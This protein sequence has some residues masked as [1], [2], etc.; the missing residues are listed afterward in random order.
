[1]ETIHPV[2]L[3]GSVNSEVT[4]PVPNKSGTFEGVD[5]HEEDLSSYLALRTDCAHR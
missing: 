4:L 1:M 5:V 2:L 3:A